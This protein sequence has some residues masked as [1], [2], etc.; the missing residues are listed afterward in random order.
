[1][2]SHGAGSWLYEHFP[3]KSWWVGN[4]ALF[5]TGAVD[6][7]TSHG[8]PP[9]A[10]NCAELE[11]EEGDVLENKQRVWEHAEEQAALF[12]AHLEELREQGFDFDAADVGEV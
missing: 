2:P 8:S 6:C 11:L 10:L 5:C 1:M 7:L 12:R 3:L 9:L 4:I